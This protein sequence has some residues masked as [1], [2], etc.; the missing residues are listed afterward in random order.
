MCLVLTCARRGLVV[1][2]ALVVA[3]GVARAQGA[4]SS[5]LSMKVD[6]VH[7]DS[8]PGAIA[9]ELAVKAGVRVYLGRSIRDRHSKLSVNLHGVTWLEA[10]ERLA[11][12]AGG[13][14][15]SVPGGVVLEER[16][17]PARVTLAGRSMSARGAIVALVRAGPMSVVVA[18]D[19]GGTVDLDVRDL[20]WTTALRGLLATSKLHAVVRGSVLLVSARA[21]A[22]GEVELGEDEPGPPLRWPARRAREPQL[23]IDVNLERV[24][25]REAIARLA[26]RVE[27]NCVIDPAVVG[28][29]TYAAKSCPWREAIDEV[30]GQTGAVVRESSDILFVG[31]PSLVTA[32]SDDDAA[33]VLGLLAKASARSF[34][35]G[36]VRGRLF[37]DLRRAAWGD[38]V[39]AI[40]SACGARAWRVGHRGEVTIVSTATPRGSFEASP[41]DSLVDGL[42]VG[43]LGDDAGREIDIAVED[44]SLH[45]I[46]SEI[47]RR[48][49]RTIVAQRGME[50]TLTVTWRKVRWR[51]AVEV[52]AWMSKSRVRSLGG[53]VL[54]LEQEPR[55]ELAFHSADLTTI[56]QL[57]TVYAGKNVLFA[58]DLAGTTSLALGAVDWA[59]ALHAIID[60]F[61]LHVTEVSPGIPL[62]SA[63]R[64]GPDAPLARA[65]R[66]GGWRSPADPETTISLD[67]EDAPLPDVVAAVVSRI[68]QPIAV[69]AGVTETVTL[70]ARTLDWR[71]A[72]DLI[73]RL[74]CCEVRRREDGLVLEQTPKTA[75]LAT[76]VPANAWFTLLGLALGPGGEEAL[77]RCADVTGELTVDLHEVSFETALLAT[78]EAARGPRADPR[79]SAPRRAPVRAEPVDDE[80]NRTRKAEVNAQ[81]KALVDRLDD[82]SVEEIFKMDFASLFAKPGGRE[83][84]E[85]KL[86]IWH[87]KGGDDLVF[88]GLKL[89]TEI[90]RGNE[91]LRAML[92]AKQAE[93]YEDAPALFDSMKELVAEMRGE[94]REEFYRYADAF[95]SRAKRLA[96]TCAK[97]LEIAEAYP[98]EVRAT[99]LDP[100]PGGKNRTVLV[101]DGDSGVG[102]VLADGDAVVGPGGRAT[103]LTIVKVNEG[104]VTLRSGDME[105]DRSLAGP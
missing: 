94:V 10:L 43:A 86:R 31:R 2:L 21:P 76:R 105:F 47:G 82:L 88:L 16:P 100:R 20:P 19:V 54:L 28:T 89:M 79:N 38:A 53:S 7:E 17:A 32:T 71:D 48:V 5:Y 15:R 18:S 90:E 42:D 83:S 49:G 27:R 65:R 102:R 37:V 97:L 92:E 50:S 12:E 60:A 24:D 26:R 11:R 58:P 1:S 62:V 51:R 30:A 80:L 84:F 72:L 44:A 93:R 68:G 95:F 45:D 67:L 104:W 29:V 34:V 96:D 78:A 3:A 87:Q 22:P 98:F 52:L 61:G 103:G 59:T 46:L 57:V 81:A 77:R 69:A 4:D 36:D 70:R 14:L 56:L 91:L 55:V 25:V 66:D 99:V 64:R 13:R 85:L 73:A 33:V 40:A 75:F 8:E 6:L 41:D 101:F 39:S 35:A 9:D 74:T 63:A 23:A